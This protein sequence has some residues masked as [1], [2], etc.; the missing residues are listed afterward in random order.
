MNVSLPQERVHPTA[1]C[2]NPAAKVTENP[3]GVADGISPINYCA[4]KTNFRKN[5]HC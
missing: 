3:S 2:G 4:A 5:L 1:K